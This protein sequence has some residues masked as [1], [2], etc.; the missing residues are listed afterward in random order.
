MK[1]F[2][3]LNTQAK[4]KG[5]MEKKNTKHDM[6]TRFAGTLMAADLG[7]AETLDQR[8]L[9]ESEG[10]LAIYYAPFDYIQTSAKVVLVGITPGL[11]QA[12]TAVLEAARCLRGGAS[13]DE[14][15]RQAKVAASFSG[16]MR[17]NLV[18]LLDGVG[19][20]DWLGLNTAA[21]LFA[22]RTDLVHY[23]SVLRYP[24]FHR[25]K[26]YSGSPAPQRSRLLLDHIEQWFHRELEALPDA[27][28]IPLGSVPRQVLFAAAEKGL[29]DEGRVLDGL[30]HPSGANAERIAYFLGRK[31]AEDC[32]SKCDPSKLDLARSSVLDK[33]AAIRGLVC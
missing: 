14:A 21:D 17:R 10:E 6:I 26:N 13:T 19:V 15:L 20:H 8:L 28:F 22:S 23:T 4:S 18:D 29:I 7:V 24:V 9:I 32:S 12:R 25:G 1:K 16:P 31:T 3:P 27:I 5:N 33:V 11:A 30:P 2:V